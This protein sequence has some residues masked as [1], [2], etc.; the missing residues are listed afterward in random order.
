MTTHLG[1]G[2]WAGREP[3][4]LG[5]PKEALRKGPVLEAQPGVLSQ[6]GSLSS[7]A[8]GK[9]LGTRVTSYQGGPCALMSTL[10]ASPPTGETPS[11]PTAGPAL[12]GLA[13]GLRGSWR[14]AWE[15]RKSVV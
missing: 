5:P 14:S 7:G 8:T 10:L 4:G 3:R 2:W 11:V 9:G 1:L 15:D 6:G 13:E 12:G